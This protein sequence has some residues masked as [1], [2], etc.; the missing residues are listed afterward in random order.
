[1]CLQ[2]RIDHREGRLKELINPS[3]IMCPIQFTQLQHGDIL[4]LHDDIPLYIFERKTVSDLSASLHDG[5]YRN[6]KLK[7]L[8]TYDHSKIYYIIEGDI[9]VT[10][11]ALKGAVINT[12]LR[13]KIGIFRTRS[14]IDT[15]Q[16]LCDIVERVKKYPEQYIGTPTQDAQ[17]RRTNRNE[18]IF[19]NMLCQIPKISLK[20]AR[21]VQET[22]KCFH[23]LHSVLDNQTY[24]ERL[25]LLQCIRIVDV[26]GNGRKI[27]VSA[28]DN[29]LKAC[30][31]EGS[32]K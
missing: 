30:F 20:T 6:Q 24:I 7:M 21:A 3:H 19:V 8:D 18:S 4:L 9:H 13:D 29:I 27:G 32:T 2:L 11:E 5:R 10:N 1:M 22:Y 25:K 16:L 28:C 23:D 15:I 31:G 12:M 14:V 26:R 17:P